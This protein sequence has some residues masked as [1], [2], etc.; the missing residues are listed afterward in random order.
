MKTVCICVGHGPRVDKGAQ[1]LNDPPITELDWNRDLAERIYSVMRG[2]P[3]LKVIV[4]H[5]RVEK[6]PP[7]TTV[8]ELGA[9]FCVELHCNAFD[10]SASGTEMIHYP[11]SIRGKRLGTILQAR[12]V[13]ALGLPNRGVK[14]PWKGRGMMF[15]EKTRCP[16]VICETM[17]IDNPRDLAT[18]T[19]NKDELSQAYAGGLIAYAMEIQ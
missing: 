15:L 17:F 10:G 12:V 14:V 6:V 13:G 3:L 16:A 8:N 1:S 2:N 4:V 11:H 9:S 19:I 7:Y 18:A 5:R